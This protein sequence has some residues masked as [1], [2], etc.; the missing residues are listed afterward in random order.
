MEKKEELT[1]SNNI[2]HIEFI[3]DKFKLSINI[4]PS[5]GL[6]NPSIKLIMVDFPEP[7]LPTIA[8]LLLTGI[9]MFILLRIRDLTFC[10]LSLILSIQMD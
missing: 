2:I 1:K 5:D 10:I 8:K 6:S 3:L 4:D 9:S 7:D